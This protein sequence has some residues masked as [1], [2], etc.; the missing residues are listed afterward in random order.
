MVT[1]PGQQSFVFPILAVKG[2]FVLPSRT[3]RKIFDIAKPAL[4]RATLPSFISQQKHCPF[5]I[6][7]FQ[8]GVIAKRFSQ[9]A[10]ETIFCGPPSE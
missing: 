5:S 8:Q 7:V 2:R 4:V 10:V 3:M 1:L 9:R 6:L